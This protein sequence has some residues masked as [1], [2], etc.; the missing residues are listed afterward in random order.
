MLQNDLVV[1][2]PALPQ[3]GRVTR[4]G[5]HYVMEHGTAVQVHETQYARGIMTSY[6]TSYIPDI[7]R[8]Q[9]GESVQ[10]M[11]LDVVQ[12]GWQNIKTALEKQPQGAVV[13][14]D[15]VIPEDL[16]NIAEAIH[17]LNVKI[18]SV[19]SAGL[20]RAICRVLRTANNLLA[21]RIT[22][23]TRQLPNIS[24]DGRV[25]VIAGSFNKQ[26]DA[27]IETALATLGD[28]LNLLELDVSKVIAQGKP[29]TTEI[30]RLRR[31]VLSSLPAQTQIV[32]R[33]KRTILKCRKQAEKDIVKALVDIIADD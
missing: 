13:V 31:L 14:A 3:N 1:I 30:E 4:N 22:D 21:P 27:Q 24:K 18:L 20:F 26:T 17:R 15:T 8:Y 5:V 6:P 11:P 28:K 25:I 7:I 32:V 33:T 23:W 19:G 12:Q 16:D 10:L 2:A 9:L 29:N